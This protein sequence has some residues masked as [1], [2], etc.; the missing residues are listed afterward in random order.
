MQNGVQG[1][2][3]VKYCGVRMAEHENN[4]VV[5]LAAVT[6]MIP[7]KCGRCLETVRVG[8]CVLAACSRPTGHHEHDS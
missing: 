5:D 7:D 2:S 6:I 1:E 3:E 8:E 4:C